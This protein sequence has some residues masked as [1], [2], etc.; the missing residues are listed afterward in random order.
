MFAQ[1]YITKAI[2]RL[3]RVIGVIRY[4]VIRMET[5]KLM[6]QLIYATTQSQST[7]SAVERFAHNP[8]PKK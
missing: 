7:N 1:M 8:A 4:I 6:K 3:L 2:N 5:T